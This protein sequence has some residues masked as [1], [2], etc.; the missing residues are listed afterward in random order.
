VKLIIPRVPV[1]PNDHL[2]HHWSKHH[3]DHKQWRKD[4]MKAL[5]RDR[6]QV[7]SIMLHRKRLLDPDNAAGSIK[8]CLDG[9]RDSGLIYDDS[10]RWILLT[11]DQ[12]KDHDEYT[13][14][15]INEVGQYDAPDR[16]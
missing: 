14:I 15:E 13:E 11:V 9:L 1:S 16:V 4:V 6:F 5:G 7:V 2:G 3:K 10:G 8:G 12:V